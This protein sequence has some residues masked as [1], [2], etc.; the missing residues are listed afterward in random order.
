[1]ETKSSPQADARAIWTPSWKANPGIEAVELDIADPD[2]IKA[3]AKKLT[4]RH[5]DL[6]VLI[7]NAGIMQPDHLKP[8]I[9]RATSIFRPTESKGE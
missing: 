4:T 5:L 6:N 2:S 7:N 8:N 9:S 1:M 3:A